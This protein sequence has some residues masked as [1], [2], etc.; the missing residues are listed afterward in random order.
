MKHV[1]RICAVLLAAVGRI[2]PVLLCVQAFV[3]P[4]DA[5]LISTGSGALRPLPIPLSPEHMPKAF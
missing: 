1:R 5:L 3:P 4:F 2:P